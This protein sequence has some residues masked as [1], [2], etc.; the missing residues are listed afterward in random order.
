MP[1]SEVRVFVEG[2]FDEGR[3]GKLALSFQ[4][5]SAQRTGVALSSNLFDADCA[6]RARNKL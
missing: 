5:T 6:Q 4:V 2:R 1:E 3:P